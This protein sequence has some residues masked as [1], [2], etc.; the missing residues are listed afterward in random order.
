[1]KRDE[2]KYRDRKIPVDWETRQRKQ[3]EDSLN[4][5]MGKGSPASIRFAHLRR[6]KNTGQFMNR[7]ARRVFEAL[8]RSYGDGR[9][10]KKPP[11]LTQTLRG[12]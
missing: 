2:M 9:L 10:Q 1:M 6:I 5:Y 12:W 3:L 7:K 8:N 4:Q 11:T